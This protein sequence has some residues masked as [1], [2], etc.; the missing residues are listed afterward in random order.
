MTHPSIFFSNLSTKEGYKEPLLFVLFVLGCGFASLA[1]LMIEPLII[2][3]SITAGFILLFINA[4]IIY[5][6]ASIF[7]RRINY[8]ETVKIVGYASA[9]LLFYVVW[10]WLVAVLLRSWL[11]Y[12]LPLAAVTSTIY[13]ILI[14]II[15]LLPALYFVLL[16]TV[17]IHSYL[18]ISWAKSIVIVLL[19]ALIILILSVRFTTI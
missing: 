14:T 8:K 16:Q 6:L 1:M 4:A 9:P 12:F 5:T 7:K 10:I 11:P 18:K 19:P 17:G 2:L 3:I 15:Q 13:T